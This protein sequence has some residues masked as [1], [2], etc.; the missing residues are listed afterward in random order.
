MLPNGSTVNGVYKKDE[1]VYF[2]ASFLA[3]L[4]LKGM[5]KTRAGIY[6]LAE[7]DNWP[8][9]RVPGKGAADGV[10]YFK[11][12]IDIEMLIRKE[13]SNLLSEHFGAQN[14]IESSSKP[15]PMMNQKT[16]IYSDNNDEHITIEAYPHIRASSG[17]GQAVPTD[18]IAMQVAINAK[19]F[20]DY[21]GMSPK[22]VKIITNYG[23]SNKPTINHGD[24]VLVDITCHSFIDDALYVIQQ[25]DNLRIKR[26]KLRLDGSIEVKSDNVK[27]FSP[28]F[29]KAEEAAEFKVIGKV[30]P[31][32][33]GK[34]DI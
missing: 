25:G 13:Y 5:P 33:F 1:S 20:R 18:Q 29:Y 11:A 28:E 10:R 17:P 30:L 15:I 24:Q 6:K 9:I 32:K 7:R 31:F 34:F 23:D 19:D 14:Y 21:I 22:N 27:D 12:P 26:I 8:V 4:H 16:N 2:S 3:G